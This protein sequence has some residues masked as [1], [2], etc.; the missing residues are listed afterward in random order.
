MTSEWATTGLVAVSGQVRDLAESLEAVFGQVTQVGKVISRLDR[1]VDQLVEERSETGTAL[2][3]HERE[4]RELTA[5]VKR[6]VVRVDWIE[7]HLRTSGN[8]SA[9]ELDHRDPELLALATTSEAGHRAVDQL[10]TPFARVGLEA[11][12]ADHQ[13]AVSLY[14][15]VVRSLLDACGQLI[16]SD[17]DEPSHSLARTEYLSAR[18]ARTEAS[19]R[20][21]SLVA[22]ARSAAERLA[23]DDAER[24]Q[25]EATISAV[26]RAEVE[27]LTRLRTRLAAAVGEGSM[28][29]AWLTGQLG[30]MPPAGAA[31]RWMDIAAGLLAYRTTYAVSDPDDPLGELP[32]SVAGHRRRW[33]ADLGRGIRDLAS[34]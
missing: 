11:V 7:R 8:V 33:H 19:R 9:I 16:E 31:Q 3:Q 25:R 23:T 30:P 4:L 18:D 14:R 21:E 34:R 27:L 20:V 6:L 32:E 22:E 2:S 24:H 1:D 29:P 15:Q 10:L 13:D 12:V 28:L 17:R 26:A 5:T